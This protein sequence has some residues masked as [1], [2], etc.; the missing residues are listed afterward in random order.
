MKHQKKQ[1]K[2]N[3]CIETYCDTQSIYNYEGETKALYCAEHK[4]I[5]MIDIKNKK[6]IEPGCKIQPRYNYEGEI[7]A[8]YCFEHKKQDMID[9]RGKKC[10]ELKCNIS[11]SYNY[12]GEIEAL[13]C[14]KHK[15]TNMVNV[16]KQKCIESGCKIRP[17]YNYDGMINAIY[18][19]KHKKTDMVD[20]THPRCIEIGCKTRPTFGIPGNKEEY[21]MAHKKKD[22]ISNP[23]KMCIIDNCN[24]I[25]IYGPNTKQLR[26][27]KH[28][29]KDDI[30]LI[31]KECNGCKLPFI[32]NANN[33]CY[34][35]DPENSMK[36][37]FAK[38][39]KVKFYLD[40]HGYKYVTF[41]KSINNSEC[42]KDRPDFLFD[43]NTHFVILEVDQNQHR[44]RVCECEFNRMI[45]ISQA[46]GMPTI[47]LRYN[48][49]EFKVN[50]KIIDINQNIRLKELELCLKY[51]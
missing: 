25:A 5:N 3:I 49:D 4:K 19:H 29:E 2:A 39:N 14:D 44:D 26:C 51:F 33:L 37:R 9:L 47:F 48:P 16:T 11:P 1:K 18:C 46:L 42:I 12:E 34:Y 8:L 28:K 36:V 50:D 32:L 22:M 40:Q 38:Q 23:K 30:N 20:I 10:I 35:C 15:K 27:E 45:N 6:C 17:N 7:K 13:Y 21:C 24:G 43:F 31:E 41:D